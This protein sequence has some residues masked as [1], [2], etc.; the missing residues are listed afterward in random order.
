VS[1]AEDLLVH[2]SRG[3]FTGR[4]GSVRHLQAG[5]TVGA[6]ASDDAGTAATRGVR[7]LVHDAVERQGHQLLSGE[8]GWAG[9][10]GRL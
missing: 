3:V 10:G 8:F 6:G 7:K 5:R 2:G 9:C 4:C 1:G